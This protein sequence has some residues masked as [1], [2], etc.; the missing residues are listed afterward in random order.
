MKNVQISPDVKVGDT[1]DGVEHPD[2][3]MR[4][5]RL[6]IRIPALFWERLR[7]HLERC[8]SSP[9]E[10]SLWEQWFTPQAVQ[11]LLSES[12]PPLRLGLTA[13]PVVPDTALRH[14]R[15]TISESLQHPLAL[16][17]DPDPA[18]RPGSPAADPAYLLILTNGATVVMRI[19]N[20]NK[21]SP[22]ETIPAR[23]DDCF[24]PRAPA[25]FARPAGDFALPA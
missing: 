20:T 24:F 22:D 23:L 19:T 6:S 14:L 21:P 5:A 9:A 2:P 1:I 4:P 12:T 11:A 7:R 13:D 15:A 10:R 25:A 18:G 17:L 8:Q 3:R 16:R